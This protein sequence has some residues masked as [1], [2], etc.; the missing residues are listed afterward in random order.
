MW[1]CAHAKPAL[2]ALQWRDRGLGEGN[3]AAWGAT[4][5]R[6]LAGIIAQ[7]PREAAAAGLTYTAGCELYNTHEADPEWKDV[8]SNFRT[9]SAAELAALTPPDAAAPFKVGHEF[10]SIMASQNAPW[11]PIICSRTLVGLGHPISVLSGRH[12]ATF[13]LC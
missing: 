5:Y 8:V 12:P 6:R 4:T 7:G 3:V 13:Y 2:Y 9:L 1:F 10:T 11:Q